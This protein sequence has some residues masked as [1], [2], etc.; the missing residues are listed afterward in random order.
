MS[1][2]LAIKDTN[3]LTKVIGSCHLDSVKRPKQS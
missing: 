2:V 1:K 3:E